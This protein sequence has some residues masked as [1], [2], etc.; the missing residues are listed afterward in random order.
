MGDWVTVDRAA[1]LVAVAALAVSIIYG[2]W[3]A[4]IATDA[5]DVAERQAAIAEAAKEEARKA[6][7]AAADVAR[8]E[9]RR[10]HLA[11]ATRD[12]E[13]LRVES[14]Q[15]PALPQRDLVALLRNTGQRIY[16]YAIDVEHAGGGVTTVRSNK[17][18]PGET[19]PVHLGMDGVLPERIVGRFDGECPCD[20]PDGE[21]HWQKVWRTPD[22]VV[23]Q[24]EPPNLH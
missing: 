17:I 18:H 7:D 21:S 15:N 23:P 19:V 14:R 13:L 1:L 8:I 11:G 3:Q 24:D 16:Q 12:V 22:P 6:A 4:N 5:K 20:Q 2:R 10:D 9:A